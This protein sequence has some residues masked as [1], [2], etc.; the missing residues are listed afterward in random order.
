MEERARWNL[1][2]YLRGVECTFKR[3]RKNDEVV[4]QKTSTMLISQALVI[5]YDATYEE[6][7]RY[8]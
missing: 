1:S 2:L 6:K 7:K 4:T 3:E 8:A 5:F